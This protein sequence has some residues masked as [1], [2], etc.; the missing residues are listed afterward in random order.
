MEGSLSPAGNLFVRPG[1]MMAFQGFLPDFSL[2]SIIQL[3]NQWLMISNL[4]LLPPLPIFHFPSLSRFWKPNFWKSELRKSERSHHSWKDEELGWRIPRF[5]PVF[6]PNL[7]RWSRW[8]SATPGSTLPSLIKTLR[9]PSRIWEIDHPSED[10]WQTFSRIDG[11]L[12]RS[13]FLPS[14]FQT[15]LSEIHSSM[16]MKIGN[17]GFHLIP[18]A[19]IETSSM[20]SSQERWIPRLGSENPSKI[21]RLGLA[22]SKNLSDLILILH[23]SKTMPKPGLMDD[24]IWSLPSILTLES[25][26]LLFSKNGKTTWTA[27]RLAQIH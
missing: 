11:N 23:P 3:M 24:G 19:W 26:L 17:L 14:I 1:W 16:M 27:R 20:E 15:K 6:Q 10:D 22:S 13:S 21:S 9:N 25:R 7:Q 4:D 18:Q 12:N 5:L 8:S 2:E